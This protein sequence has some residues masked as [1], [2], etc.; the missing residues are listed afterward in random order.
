MALSDILQKIKDEAAKKAAFMKQVADDEIRKMK[1]E[2]RKKAEVRKQEI[3]EKGEEKATSVVEKARVLAKMEARN[4][5]LADKRDVINAVYEEAQKEL[6]GLKGAE[7]EKVLVSMM[8]ATSKSMPKGH[9]F[10]PHGMKKVT[11][12]AI[13]KAKVDYTVKEEHPDLKGGFILY[14]GKTEMNLSFNYLLGKQVRPKT[15]LEV[16]KILFD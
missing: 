11:E 3:A 15:E 14:D 9:L 12:D 7:Y 16:A 10:V 4:K 13:A 5:L 8:K 6:N 2:A 1:D